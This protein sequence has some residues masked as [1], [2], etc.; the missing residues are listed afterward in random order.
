[1]LGNLYHSVCF[2]SN[3]CVDETGCS[4]IV[5]FCYSPPEWDMGSAQSGVGLVC[6]GGNMGINNL[7]VTKIER[8]LSTQCFFYLCE[9]LSIRF[10]RMRHI[11][12]AEAQHD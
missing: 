6:D 3:L 10:R 12:N 4:P 5:A 8:A 11:A 1:M 7:S 9:I 2:L